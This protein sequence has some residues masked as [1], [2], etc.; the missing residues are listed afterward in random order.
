[1]LAAGHTTARGL[2]SAKDTSS[3]LASSASSS[4]VAMGRVG[5]RR[6]LS[7]SATWVLLQ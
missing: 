6:P 2:S 3:P 7:R 4:A 1:M 5:A